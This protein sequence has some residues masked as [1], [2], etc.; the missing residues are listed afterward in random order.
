MIANEFTQKGSPPWLIQARFYML[1]FQVILFLMG[2]SA[3]AEQTRILLPNPLGCS[4][5]LTAVLGCTILR[6]LSAKVFGLTIGPE[7]M[8]YETL[9]NPSTSPVI[10]IDDCL[11]ILREGLVQ[12]SLTRVF[13]VC[14]SATASR[15]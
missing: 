1:Y 12:S 14:Y 5:N 9:L 8:E 4:V 2:M 7:L 11:Q 6:L 10:L 3:L 13:N 15:W